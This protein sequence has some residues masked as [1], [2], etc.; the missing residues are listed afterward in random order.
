MFDGLDISVRS[1]LYALTVLHLPSYSSKKWNRDFLQLFQV[2]LGLTENIYE[3]FY[4]LTNRS[5]ECH[6]I[7]SSV[8]TDSA[9]EAFLSIIDTAGLDRI[10]L[11]IGVSVYLRFRFHTIFL[12]CI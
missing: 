5:S 2:E 9:S 10:D 3:A 7:L 8:T 1:A 11:F 12:D 6:D 4:P